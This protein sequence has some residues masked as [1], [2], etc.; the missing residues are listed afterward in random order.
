MKLL[1]GINLRQRP[2]WVYELYE[3]IVRGVLSQG[4]PLELYGV[5]LWGQ[6][7]TNHEIIATLAPTKNATS[8][9]STSTIFCPIFRFIF[10]VLSC[11]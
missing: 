9:L 4:T 11:Q 10:I 2:R 1:A 7:S 3:F 8:R 5:G 6:H